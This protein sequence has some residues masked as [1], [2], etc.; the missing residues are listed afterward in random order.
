M[1][2]S[3][4]AGRSPKLGSSFVAWL[5]QS[6]C[7]AAVADVCETLNRSRGCNEGEFRSAGTDAE[8]PLSF[9]QT[10]LIAKVLGQ[11]AKLTLTGRVAGQ[12]RLRRSIH[13]WL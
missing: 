2:A 9:P 5:I 10:S 6:A 1:T 13:G 7:M 3:L 8:F 4:G 12:R 11:E